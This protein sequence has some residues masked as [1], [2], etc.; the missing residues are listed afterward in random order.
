MKKSAFISDILF[1]FFIA[2]VFTLCLFRY[3]RLS[4]PLALLLG[5]VCGVLAACG[6]GAL[7]QSKRKTYLLKRSDEAQKQRFLDHLCLLGDEQKTKYFCDVL[8]KTTDETVKRSGKLRLV[9]GEDFYFLKFRF[10]PVSAD[11]VASA[12][13]WNTGKKKI[14]LCNR[15]DEDAAALCL[16]LGLE[17]HTGERVYAET[18][19]ADALP[20]EYLGEEKSENKKKR[21]LHLW[22]HRRNSRPFF[23]SGMMLLVTSLLTPF[24]YYYLVFGSVLLLSAVLIR[25]FGYSS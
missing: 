22:F 7:L 15:I 12:A 5:G 1:T 9:G 16:R 24:P 6:I 4:L 10:A 8:R 19:K 23:I 20:A 2:S 3:L 17:L 13:R 25:I 21:R 18:K 14:L 11:E